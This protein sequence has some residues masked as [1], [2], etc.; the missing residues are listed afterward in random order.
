MLAPVS[1][2]LAGLVVIAAGNAWVMRTVSEVVQATIGRDLMPIIAEDVPRRNGLNDS[3]GLLRNAD[4]ARF[5]TLALSA[6]KE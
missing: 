2:P 5:D 4:R 3:I 1:I 6:A